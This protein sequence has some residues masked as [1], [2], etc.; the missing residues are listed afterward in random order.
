[1]KM[2]KNMMTYNNITGILC[3]IVSFHF[4]SK[5][6]Y[7]MASV[8]ALWGIAKFLKDFNDVIKETVNKF[9]E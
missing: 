6:N 1:M 7:I 3:V 9:F 8:F 5:E 2:I 4:L